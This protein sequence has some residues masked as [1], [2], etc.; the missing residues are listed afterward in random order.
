MPH[1]ESESLKALIDKIKA[2]KQT[3]NSQPVSMPQATA[4]TPQTP[5]PKTWEEMQLEKQRSQG[6]KTG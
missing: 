5:R 6:P 4:P 2:Q 1:Y 3:V